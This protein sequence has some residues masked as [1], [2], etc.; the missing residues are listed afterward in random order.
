MKRLEAFLGLLGKEIYASCPSMIGRWN[1]DA[2]FY[3]FLSL[4]NAAG[5]ARRVQ[6][7]ND[8]MLS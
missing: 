8:N 7:C 2:D 5:K 1:G 4:C 6:G 3:N